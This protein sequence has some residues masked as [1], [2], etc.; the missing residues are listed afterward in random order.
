[1]S[2]VTEAE[3][4]DYLREV[5]AELGEIDPSEVEQQSE[6]FDLGLDSLRS[7]ELVVRMERRFGIRLTEGEIRA[8]RTIADIISLA[9]TKEV[10]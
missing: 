8:V 9:M 5:V 6:L 7:L 1:M 4:F 10:A 2:S 3:I